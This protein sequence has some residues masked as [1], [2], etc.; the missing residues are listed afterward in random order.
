MVM[1]ISWLA[2]NFCQKKQKMCLIACTSPSP[3][4]HIYWPYAPSPTLEQFLRAIWEAV[5][6]AIVLILF[7]IK[8][9]S[10]LSYCAFFLKPRIFRY[11]VWGQSTWHFYSVFPLS[12]CPPCSTHCTP[13]TSKL[14]QPKLSKT[15]V[16]LGTWHPS[17]KRCLESSNLIEHSGERLNTWVLG[18]DL[19][20][21]Y[22]KG[23]LG[24]KLLWEDREKRQCFDELFGT[25]LGKESISH[26][27]VSDSLWP[28]G[29]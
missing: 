18:N 5:S 29:L 26:S 1:T 6:Q 14:C 12:L 22:N 13:R 11:P 21:V 25:P 17:L 24:R 15:K 27:V 9:N 23:Q 16:S 28:H 8:L 3:K 2:E 20:S 10:Q 19:P 4:S 7:Q